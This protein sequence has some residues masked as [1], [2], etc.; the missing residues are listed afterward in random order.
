MEHKD[1]YQTNKKLYGKKGPPPPPPPQKK[2]NLPRPTIL[3]ILA[4]SLLKHSLK[5]VI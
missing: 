3:E 4:E 1:S 5:R 2:K